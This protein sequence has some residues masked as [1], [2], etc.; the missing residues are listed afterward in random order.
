[1]ICKR[2]S[3]ALALVCALA[4]LAPSFAWSAEKYVPKH[5]PAVV[6]FD[7]HDLDG[8]DVFIKGQGLNND[9]DHVFQV[10]H[11]VLHVSGKTMGYVITKQPYQN[12]YLR[13]EF[14]WG[15]KTYAPRQGQARDSGILY[16]VQGEQK[17]WP[18]SVEFQINEACT[19]D[20]WM[21]DGAAVTGKDGK[22]VTGP[23][24]SSL[25]IDRFNKG[26][27]Q[28]VTG[29]RDPVNELEKPHGEWNVVELI[30]ENGHVRHYV[31]GKLANEGTD[32]FPSSGKILFQSE[33]AEVYFRNMKL[34]PLK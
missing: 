3:G 10:E 26:P 4:C 25:K 23:D 28:N 11:G 7:G 17:V 8:L 22:R 14:K 27:V 21:T 13:A 5:G 20:L 19:G 31:N 1:M 34:Y 15:E 29:F 18:R 9:P 2:R 30:N 12:Y 33:G 24:G 6:L 16:N 32:A